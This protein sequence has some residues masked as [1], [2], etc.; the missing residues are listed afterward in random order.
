MLSTALGETT[1]PFVSSLIHQHYGFSTSLNF[2]G[3]FLL[4]FAQ[5]Y[6]WSVCG[7]S[8]FRT[9]DPSTEKSIQLSKHVSFNDET[10]AN[11]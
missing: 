5:L 3:V 8:I 1:G 9:N 7:V 4:G 6:F 11:F 10:D 2:M